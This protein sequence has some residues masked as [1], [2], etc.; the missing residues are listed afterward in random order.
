MSDSASVALG[1][2]IALFGPRL[3]S[4]AERQPS[5]FPGPWRC[6][7][8]GQ[9]RLI[10][11]PRDPGLGPF[12]EALGQLECLCGFLPSRRFRWVARVDGESRQ[13]CQV[14]SVQQFH[15]RLL[16][17]Q[18]SQQDID[19][20]SPG[21]IHFVED[22]KG[23]DPFLNRLL[24]MEAAYI[25]QVGQTP[26]RLEILQRLLQPSA[27]EVQGAIVAHRGVSPL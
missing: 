14:R 7:G 17:S 10:T 22:Q 12:H 26:R 3:R 15:P 21:E 4:P 23:L 2:R 6:S 11:G 19:V 1:F 16:L 24:T 20:V 5:R 9:R 25:W 13:S 18:L 27:G 8:D